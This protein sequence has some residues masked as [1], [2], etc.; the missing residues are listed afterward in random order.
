MDFPIQPVLFQAEKKNWS[1][2]VWILMESW[3]LVVKMVSWEP[4]GTP[5]MPPSQEIAGL[6]TE[7][8]TIV[9]SWGPIKALFLG[10]GGIGIA[11]DTHDGSHRN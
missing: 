10:N 7:F 2:Q 3:N 11:L 8:T 9:P 6:I 1:G 5:P 4:K